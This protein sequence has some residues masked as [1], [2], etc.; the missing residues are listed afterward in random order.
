MLVYV[1]YPRPAMGRR[2]GAGGRA[3]QTAAWAGARQPEAAG[4]RGRRDPV[5]GRPAAD[6][7]CRRC[8]G[9]AAEDGA[10]RTAAA[11]PR[12]RRASRAYRCRAG[13]HH[14]GRG[15]LAADRLA[16]SGNRRSRGRSLRLPVAGLPDHFQEPI[17]Q[18]RRSRP[19]PAALWRCGDGRAAG[20]AVAR[21]FLPH[22]GL[23]PAARHWNCSTA[24]PS[25]A[26]AIAKLS[27]RSSQCSRRTPT[28][29]PSSAVPAA[30]CAG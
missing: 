13:K 15:R 24:I 9:A 28:P 22:A 25:S 29:P 4:Q 20:P 8:V 30:A 18:H 16:L 26:N 3:V 10:A 14:P 12:G 27:K 17:A 21:L 6:Q 1:Y 11:M 19:L 5:S 23:L 7:A 2:R